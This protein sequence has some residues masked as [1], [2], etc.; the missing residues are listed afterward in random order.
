MFEEMAME[1]RV[2]QKRIRRKLCKARGNVPKGVR[3]EEVV[4]LHDQDRK[5][6]LLKRT[7]KGKDFILQTDISCIKSRSTYKALGS[8]KILW[9]S[10]F[11]LI[12]FQEMPGTFASILYKRKLRLCRE[13]CMNCS[14]SGG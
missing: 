14:R 12:I 1:V 10:L 2:A 5:K 8:L 9:N 13:D 7:V 11:H 6:V 4:I 3:S